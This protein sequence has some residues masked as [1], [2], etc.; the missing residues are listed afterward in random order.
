[1]PNVFLALFYVHSN[2]SKLTIFRQTTRVC[3][4][5][6]L[7]RLGLPTNWTESTGR[8]SLSWPSH[9][10][11]FLPRLRSILNS[12]R[13]LGSAVSSPAGFRTQPQ[14]KTNLMHF[15]FKIWHLVTTILMIFLRINFPIFNLETR[16][17]RYYIQCHLCRA[18]KRGIWR[19]GKAWEG[20]MRP[21]YG[22]SREIRDG[23][24]P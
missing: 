12:A 14:P 19:P 5:V 21:R 20:T 24:Q 22:T 18:E 9:P 7:P 3:P 1:M 11:S 16:T 23:W 13:G 6:Q 8:P 15:S 2:C 4:R 17:L 10:Y